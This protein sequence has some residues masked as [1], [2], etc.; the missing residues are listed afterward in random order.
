MHG[1]AVRQVRG[2]MR[3]LGMRWQWSGGRG[4][5]S[6]R[7]MVFDALTGVITRPCVWRVR[8]RLLG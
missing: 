3:S 1:V 6:L 7:A 5:G 4:G 8:V 2:L